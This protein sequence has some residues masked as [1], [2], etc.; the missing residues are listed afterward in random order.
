MVEVG[1]DNQEV[2]DSSRGPSTAE[3]GTNKAAELKKYLE[4]NP[5]CALTMFKVYAHLF[6]EPK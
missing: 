6:D 2:P 1:Q 3:A 5:D 4:A